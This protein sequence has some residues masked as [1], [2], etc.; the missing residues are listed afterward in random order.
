MAGQYHFKLVS[1][2]YNID[3]GGNGLI[4]ERR[5]WPHGG[6]GYE[7][8]EADLGAH[9]P[10]IGGFTTGV[11]SDDLLRSGQLR[12]FRINPDRIGL[13][14]N[15]D[16]LTGSA[17]RDLYRVWQLG[18]PV[19][20][21]P[22]WDQWTLWCSTFGQL[23]PGAGIAEIGSNLATNITP[24]LAGG[25][26][27][28][29]RYDHQD[30]GWLTRLAVGEKV[31]LV[32]GMIGNAILLE[33]KAT[34]RAAANPSWSTGG[35]AFVRTADD[36]NNDMGHTKFFYSDGGATATAS[37]T[38]TGLT[39]GVRYTAYVWAKGTGQLRI[40]GGSTNGT[41]VTL[42]PNKWQLVWV[43]WT[44]SGTSQTITLAPNI[45]SGVGC[46]ATFTS[47]QVEEGDTPTSYMDPA[48]TPPTQAD[49]LKIPTGQ[50]GRS[51][52]LTIAMWVRRTYSPAG[53]FK[54]LWSS[55]DGGVDAYIRQST[56]NIIEVN[57]INTLM[58]TTNLGAPT[59]AW[60]QIVVTRAFNTS[61]QRL[62]SAVYHNG[63]LKVSASTSPPVSSY[64]VSTFPNGMWIGSDRGLVSPNNYG[65]D[66]PIDRFRVDGRAW[67]L[68][69]VE[70]DYELHRR[71]AIRG[72]LAHTQGRL[73][74]FT[75]VP[76]RFRAGIH[77]DAM[78]GTL[79]LEQVGVIP[80]G[81]HQ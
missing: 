71:D 49:E 14:V 70:D 23:E 26:L 52:D 72:F 61:N 34:N 57:L 54:Y 53:A 31:K 44:S 27:Y 1:S 17:I 74:R 56:T 16:Y 69:D 81:I 59:G 11:V 75:N 20:F 8:A 63:V 29:A 62:E 36:G 6:L 37:L 65:W 43:T 2:P 33:R 60:E 79:Q 55:N 32:P 15:L 13:A 67:T 4:D 38:Q 78:M 10:V 19:A 77:P 51:V 48:I 42:S 24:R 5:I 30:K 66:Q 50:L 18:K 40:I 45:G 76:Q 21:T 46:L 68:Q 47:L 28:T 39:N 12:A 7:Y 41:M 9:V 58:A 3:T 73:F 35:N 64:Q 25:D 22:W 80:A